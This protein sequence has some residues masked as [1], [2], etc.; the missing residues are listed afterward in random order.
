VAV[1]PFYSDESRSL[2]DNLQK[3]AAVI[4]TN[5][6]YCSVLVVLRSSVVRWNHAFAESDPILT[7]REF[8]EFSHFVMGET[9]S[10]RGGWARAQ[11]ILSSKY[12][13][14]S[15]TDGKKFIRDER[16]NRLIYT[17]GLLR[18]D[19]KRREVFPVW[20]IL[21]RSCLWCLWM[22]S[23]THIARF[24]I[25]KL[26]LRTQKQKDSLLS[27]ITLLHRSTV[28]SYPY[29]HHRYN[30]NAAIVS[31]IFCSRRYVCTVC[32]SQVS[33][34]CF[35]FGWSYCCF[36]IRSGSII[37]CFSNVRRNH[38]FREFVMLI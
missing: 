17:G 26:L 34:V 20:R 32:T 19:N 21:C 35:L 22:L 24:H 36:G 12:C 6:W 11:P 1:V 18:G 31:N 3:H 25:N 27:W 23:R 15:S 13:G 8:Q 28:S 9:G 30:N 38:C 4:R 16:N 14:I 37:F 7:S 29:S 2:D 10:P 33:C 5:H